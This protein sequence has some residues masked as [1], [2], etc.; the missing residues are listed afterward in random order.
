MKLVPFE[1]L[2]TV[3]YLHSIA[4]M[5]VS[6]VISEIFNG[7]TLKTG[8]W[9]CSR[10]LKMAPFD[11]P[12]TTFY[13]SVIVNSVAVN[14]VRTTSRFL[15]TPISLLAGH[16]VYLQQRLRP[17]TEHQ[18]GMFAV[19][20]QFLRCNTLLELCVH[21]TISIHLIKATFCSGQWS[22][23]Q[24]SLICLDLYKR[25]NWVTRSPTDQ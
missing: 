15:V 16:T 22:C 8:I 11:R 1:S 20:R 21:F 18:H 7:V 10:S 4:T 6:L 17:A 19:V 24:N 5:A 2:G 3:F 12:Y 25:P 13:W 23:I 14:R 9:G